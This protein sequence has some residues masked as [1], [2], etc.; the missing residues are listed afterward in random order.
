MASQSFTNCTSLFSKGLKRRFPGRAKA[1]T[2]DSHQ[3]T[4]LLY[5][6]LRHLHRGRGPFGRIDSDYYQHANVTLDFNG[7]I[8]TCTYPLGEHGRMKLRKTYRH[9]PVERQK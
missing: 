1:L 3:L 5:Q 2:P 9:R 4:A 8:L 7:H 6:Q